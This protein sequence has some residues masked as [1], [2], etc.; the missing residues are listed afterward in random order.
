[1]T[2]AVVAAV[3]A[4]PGGTASAYRALARRKT[5]VLVGL[6]A[7]LAGSLVADMMLG[8]ARFSAGE[9]LHALLRAGLASRS[10]C[11]W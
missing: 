10:R 9:V 5:L 6:A 2:T 1:M 3:E 4:R 11:G 7:L 8:P